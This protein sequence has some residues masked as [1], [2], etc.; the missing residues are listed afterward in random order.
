[1]RALVMCVYHIHITA[2]APIGNSRSQVS[3]ASG[4]RM[5]ADDW[6]QMDEFTIEFEQGTGRGV[7]QISRPADDQVEYRLADR[8]V[9]PTSP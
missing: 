5:P 8:P 1:M 7:A 4:C 3:T 2:S 6:A 9:R